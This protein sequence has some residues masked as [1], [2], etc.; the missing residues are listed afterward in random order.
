[1]VG[2]FCYPLSIEDPA[3]LAA[4]SYDSIVDVNAYRAFTVAVGVQPSTH[5]ASNDVIR[6]LN[7]WIDTNLPGHSS[8]ALNRPS[9]AFRRLLVWE[10][11]HHA[12]QLHL[13]SPDAHLWPVDVALGMLSQCGK[14]VAAEGRITRRGVTCVKMADDASHTFRELRRFGRSRGSSAGAYLPNQSSD[15]KS[16]GSAPVSFSANQPALQ[17]ADRPARFDHLQMG[18]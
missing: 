11:R 8:H 1:M 18:C 4:Q 7:G 5:L 13:P 12:L 3:D 6:G 10:V 9:D 15:R 16:R 17:P 2:G 14:H